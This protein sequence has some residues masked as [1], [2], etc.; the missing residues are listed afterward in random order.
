MMGSRWR[1]KPVRLT[2]R[3]VKLIERGYAM[4]IIVSYGLK[5]TILEPYGVP[6]EY[7]ADEIL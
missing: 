3:G 7:L 4:T 5:L 2:E 6:T 1:D